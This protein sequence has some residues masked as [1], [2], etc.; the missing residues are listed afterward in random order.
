MLELED[1]RMSVVEDAIKYNL[2]SQE[3]IKLYEQLSFTLEMMQ[4]TA[5]NFTVIGS[6]IGGGVDF[7]IAT[8]YPDGLPENVGSLFFNVSTDFKVQ[9]EESQVF[10]GRGERLFEINLKKVR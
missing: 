7:S 8:P 5:N 2:A 6:G 1:S 9:V 3:E 4:C 10:A